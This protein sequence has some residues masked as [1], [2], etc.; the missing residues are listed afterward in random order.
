M[1]LQELIGIKQYAGQTLVNAVKKV[2]KKYGAE[3]FHGS[4]AV[5]LVPK[6]NTP[7]VYKAWLK[8][9]AYEQYVKTAMANQS[10]PF[11][12]KFFGKVVE[13]KN[14]FGD[15]QVDSTGVE[16]ETDTLKVV[17]VERLKKGKLTEVKDSVLADVIEA[18]LLGANKLK[19][20]DV[21]KAYLKQHLDV[22]RQSQRMH[23]NMK[24]SG[25]TIPKNDSE[26]LEMHNIRS[27]TAAYNKLLQYD[28]DE[29]VDTLW[30]IHLAM[31]ALKPVLAQAESDETDSYEVWSDLRGSNIMFRD[32]GHLV[33]TDPIATDHAIS[34]D[35]S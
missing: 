28:L 29:L 20:K 15:A 8:D 17:R 11:F 19:S 6:G 30:E 26:K 4:F 35:M 12:P 1:L 18:G 34:I 2:A 9:S 21:I 33:I 7:Y 13:L 5:V 3:F 25:E 10:N 31:E 22:L 16:L 27:K 32:D 24:Y 23:S 14:I